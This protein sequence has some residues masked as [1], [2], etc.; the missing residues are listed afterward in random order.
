MTQA[1]CSKSFKHRI[2]FEIAPSRTQVLWRIWV[3]EEHSSI[4]C[5]IDESPL[6]LKFTANCQN[7]PPLLA[8]KTAKRSRAHTTKRA[9]ALLRDLVCEDF[10]RMSNAPPKNAA[11][12]GCALLT[13]EKAD[14]IQKNWS[15]QIK[16]NVNLRSSESLNDGR[17]ALEQGRQLNLH[18]SAQW[19]AYT[20]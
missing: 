10:C 13:K 11:E 18:S 8:H 3:Q 4:K 2:T 9:S 6:E 5:N 16:T 20:T 14:V 1:A 15:R 19:I 12:C 17:N 7:S